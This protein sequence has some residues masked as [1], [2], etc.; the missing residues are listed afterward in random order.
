MDPSKF[1]VIVN[2]PPPCSIRKLQILQEKSNFLQLSIVNYANITKGFMHLLK[3]DTPFL[4]DESTQLAF[5][6]LKKTL[7]S[8][9]LLYPP[10]YTKDFILYLAA[11]NSM[12]G[13]VLVL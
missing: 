6:A 9:P 12:I 8:S 5:E 13:V 3:Q 11:S 2:L 10:H 7:L 1:K 4:W